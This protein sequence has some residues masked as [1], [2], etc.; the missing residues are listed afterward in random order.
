MR[1]L[2]CRVRGIPTRWAVEMRL[3]GHTNVGA[4]LDDTAPSIDPFCARLLKRRYGLSV[5]R[6][7]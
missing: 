5:G 7:M 4:V 2:T 3:P 1:G 6:D